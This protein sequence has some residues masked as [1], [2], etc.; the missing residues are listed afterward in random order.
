MSDSV[1]LPGQPPLAVDGPVPLDWTDEASWTGTR[2]AIGA[3]TGLDPALYT[4]PD[5]FELETTRVFERAWVCVGLRSELT[6]PGTVLVRPMGQR[7]ILVTVDSQGQIHGFLNAC[8]HRGTELADRDCS[9]RSTIRCPYHRWGY[10]LDGTLVSTP[11]YDRT[12]PDQSDQSDQSA[13]RDSLDL[14]PVRLASW[15]CLVFACLDPRTPPLELWLGDLPERLAG[16]QLE[17]WSRH[18]QVAVEV[19]ANW[20]LITENFQECYHLPWV[21]PSLA[22]VS[23]VEDHYR[24][25]GP[26][27]YCGQTTTPVS[28]ADGS[29][30]LSLP[31]LA[32]L[33]GS[34]SISGRHVAIFPNVVMSVLP[35][36]VF[37]MRIEPLGPG[38]SREHC[39]FLLPDPPEATDQP[40]S[41]GPADQGFATIRQFW[42]DVNG[43]DIDVVERS[44]RGLQSGRVP[45][46]PLVPG[47]EEPLHRFHNILADHLT[48]TDPAAI[49]VPS[50]GQT[51]NEVRPQGDPS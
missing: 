7:S 20:K 34:D 45:P 42:L 10:G 44:Q 27:M 18:D 41:A 30:W 6:A 47:F 48:A 21:H 16:Y 37:V 3:A 17:R 51:N 35:N 13:D 49:P 4:D 14:V 26:G 12:T 11:R 15:G 46:G 36:H 22:T 50:D 2:Q 24:F 25:Q 32:G 29:S 23:R 43:Q 19:A 40:S 1:Q 5:A 9:V 28:D 33:T 8:R 39:A 38:R 31:P